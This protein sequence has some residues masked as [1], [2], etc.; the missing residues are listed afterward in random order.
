MVSK[1]TQDEITRMDELRELLDT[2]EGEKE[3]TI[4][5]GGFKYTPTREER[6]DL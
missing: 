5:K 1:E 3:S 4:S 2:R 6:H